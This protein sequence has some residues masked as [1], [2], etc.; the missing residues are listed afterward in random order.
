MINNIQILRAFAAIYV[1]I[2]HTALKLEQSWPIAKYGAS[3][4]D[5]FFVISGFIITYS[6]IKRPNLPVQTFFA[7]RFIRIIPIYWLVTLFYA[8]LLLFLPRAFE[9]HSFDLFHLIKSLLFLSLQEYPVLYVG[10]TLSYEMYFYILFGLS[11]FTKKAMA[12]FLVL[13]FF[14]VSTCVGAYLDTPSDYRSDV[15]TSPLLLEFCMGILLAYLFVKG[16]TIHIP[17][18]LSLTLLAILCALTLTA[19]P[20]IVGYGLPMTLLFVAVTFLRSYEIKNSML[21]LFGDASYSIY[22]THVITLP[23]LHFLSKKVGIYGDSTVTL[24]VLFLLYVLISIVVGVCTY[25]IL[26]RPI[27]SKLNGRYRLAFESSKEQQQT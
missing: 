2:Y 25:V 5:L 10:W 7:K 15:A 4:V 6:F 24:G 8:G 1:V 13:V 9:T 23:A 12:P 20:R 18:A 26:E 3:G 21:K 16:A 17:V 14:I 19:Y 11:L 27:T 22:L